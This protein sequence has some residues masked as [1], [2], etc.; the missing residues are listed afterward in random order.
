MSP[1][2]RIN[3]RG[4]VAIDF[5]TFFA[6]AIWQ[7]LFNNY[8]RETFGATA[9]QIGIIQ[10]VREVPGLLGFGV[11]LLAMF[12]SELR[13]STISIAINGLGLIIAG[14]ANSIWMLGVGTLVMSTGFHY[15]VSANQS[16]L[17]NY[18]RGHES[19]RLQGVMASWEAMAG[20]AGT[21]VVFLLSF[22]FG[23]RMILVSTGAAFVVAGIV[24]SFLFKGNRA[25]GETS[26]FSMKK[27]YWLYYVISFLRGCRRHMFTTFAI[28]L[29]V[30]NYKLKIEYTALLFFI[31]SA[32]T[33]VT[34]K[35]LGNLTERLGERFLLAFTSFLLIFI[36]AGYAYIAS[37]YVLLAFFVIDS[38]LFGSGVA[39]NSYIRKIAPKRDLTNALSIGLT[40]NHIA[41]VVI[42][43]AGGVMWDTLGFRV[44][45]IMGAV[46]VML[47]M[48]FSLLVKPPKNR[49]SHAEEAVGMERV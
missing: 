42:P 28:F 5:V 47:D 10:A 6:F 43:I 44:T 32:I 49:K 20:V 2:R 29:L 3:F 22:V 30:A 45:F 24:L 18:I 36:F 34:N 46:I 48:A 11:G 9:S 31:T 25:A 35:Q 19:G 14:T 4:I 13:I 17:L 41:A 8:S 38:V 15:F 21:I 33:I 40:M 23:Y 39:L 7:V 12:A 26:K 27:S 37:L 16:L 1:S